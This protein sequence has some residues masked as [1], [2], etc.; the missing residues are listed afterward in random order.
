MKVKISSQK[1]RNDEDKNIQLKD[2]ESHYNHDNRGL[3]INGLIKSYF[4]K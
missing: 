4:G 2:T 1:G 3:D